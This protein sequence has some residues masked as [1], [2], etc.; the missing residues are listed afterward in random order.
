M[1]AQYRNGWRQMHLLDDDPV[2]PETCP[3]CGA[4]APVTVGQMA[5][6]WRLQIDGQWHIIDPPSYACDECGCFIFRVH[7]LWVVLD[8]VPF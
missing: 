4:G 7:G 1:S 8:A 6:R 5:M 3:D 2:A